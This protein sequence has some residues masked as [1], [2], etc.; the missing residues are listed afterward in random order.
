MIWV[1]IDPGLRSGAWGA[2]GSHGEYIACDAILEVDGRVVASH[3]KQ[4][5]LGATAGL[6]TAQIVIEQVFGMPKQGISS[7]SKFMRAVGSIEAVCELTRCPVHFVTPQCWKK[8]F[9][10][11][12]APKDASL[13]M[14]R[15]L[16]PNAPLKLKKHHNLAEALLMAEWGRSEFA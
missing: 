14:A 11:I 7:T 4:A 1:G 8:H 9:C 16:W 10:L 12:K 5:I 6:E 2:I 15:V 3:L 13:A